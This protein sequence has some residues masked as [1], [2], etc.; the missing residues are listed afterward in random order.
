MDQNLGAVGL[1]RAQFHNINDI[2]N[3]H[4]GASTHESLVITEEKDSQTADAIDIDEEGALFM[5]M[6]NIVF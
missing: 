5:T 2:V 3:R 1:S 4:I 6:D